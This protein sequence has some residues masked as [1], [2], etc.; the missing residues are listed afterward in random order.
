MDNVA[1][2]EVKLRDAYVFSGWHWLQSYWK[3]CRLLA[4]TYAQT[5]SE[6]STDHKIVKGDS[7]REIENVSLSI[8]KDTAN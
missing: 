4:P 7:E 2:A 8:I 1:T 6:K 5:K 3:L